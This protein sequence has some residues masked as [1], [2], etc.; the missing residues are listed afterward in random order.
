MVAVKIHLLCIFD[1]QEPYR[2]WKRAV[3]R[4]MY[5]T[6]LTVLRMPAGDFE[7]RVLVNLLLTEAIM[8][9]QCLRFAKI[10]VDTVHLEICIRFESEAKKF[11]YQKL[12]VTWCK[13]T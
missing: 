11:S 2:S 7:I 6:K 9:W 5:E 1:L 10:Q 13:I 3:I 8:G 4:S 12:S